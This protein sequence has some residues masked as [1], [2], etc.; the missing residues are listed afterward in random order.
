MKTGGVVVLAVEKDAIH[1]ISG[2]DDQREY[3]DPRFTSEDRQVLRELGKEV[4]EIGSLPVQEKKKQLWSR[5]N[6][7]KP[8]RPL[9]WLNDICWHELDLDGELHLR[10]S[11][12]FCQQIE[13][14]LR[15]TI[16]W[17]RHMRG[18]LV[19]D[20]VIFCPLAVEHSG[21]GIQVDED[22]AE[23]DEAN[24]VVS[25]H[26]HAT[27]RD[28]ED[29]E[30]ISFPNIGHNRTKSEL[31]LQAYQDIFDGVLPVHQRGTPGFAFAPWDD[32]VR[33]TEVQEALMNLAVKPDFI[34]RLVD[35][36]VRVCLETLDQYVSLGLLALNSCNVRIGSGAYGYT[37]ELPQ[38][39]FDGK[40]VRAADIW[41]SATAQIFSEVSPAMHEEFALN[42]ERR[43]LERFGLTYYGCCEPL[44]HKIDML[45]TIPNLRK[46]SISPW[47]DAE[48]AA[49]QIGGDYVF[50]YKPSPAVLARDTW[51]PELARTELQDVLRVTRKYGCNVEIIMKDI[52]TVRYQPERLW[53]WVEIA[54]EVVS[55]FS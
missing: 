23:T 2:I 43:W 19:V 33:L 16:Y 4:A 17:W 30:K 37:D 53:E 9:V 47:N 28:P 39:D 13:S 15:Q 31:Y 12:P 41:G 5:L 46:I 24:D 7:L 32:I 1:R 18:D 22:I 49:E 45:R 14:G 34:H 3:P 38:P 54:G 36:L 40:H 11:T 44:H 25:H 52:S 27:I 20:P 6:R 35:R 29:I 26:Y 51:N 21:I 8:T 50:S 55:R 10:T 48:R 42:Y